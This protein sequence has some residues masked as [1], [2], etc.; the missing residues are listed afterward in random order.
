M[1]EMIIIN[2][3]SDILFTTDDEFSITEIKA[4]SGNSYVNVDIINLPDKFSL[5][6]AYPNPFNPVTSFNYSLPFESKLS[7]HVYDIQGRLIETL[8]DGLQ[9]A[10]Y[11]DLSWNAVN[12][13]SGLYIIHVVGKSDSKMYSSQ[14]KLMLLK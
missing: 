6:Q 2:P 12:Q 3:E 11:H 5:S 7:I 4:A 8:Y 9:N 14:Q 10:G 1:T 13:A